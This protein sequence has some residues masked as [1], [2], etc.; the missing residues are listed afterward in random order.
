MLAREE[1][2]EQA[3]F[4]RVL[5]ERLPENFPMQELM[6]QIK[7]ELLATT[8]LPMAI[9]YLLTELRH[10]GVMSG[11]MKRLA[12]YF[13]PYQTYIVAEAENER[14]RFDMRV[15]IDI[16]RH[17]AA[18]RAESPTPA[19][20]FMYQFETIC[21]NRLRYDPGLAAIARD[22]M[23]DKD[24]QQWILTVRRQIGLIDF[25][26]LIYVRS[27]EYQTTRTVPG[28]PEPPPEKPILF[29][30]K[31]G[32]IALANRRK[33]P[34][35]LFA[36]L[37]RHLNYPMAPRLKRIDESREILPQLLR[38]VERLET[39]IKLLEEENRHGIDITKF[40]AVPEKPIP[41]DEPPEE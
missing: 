18:Y 33:D 41:L 36:A 20:L 39:R 25:A 5:A 35:Y 38:R 3:Y 21:R 31:E 27:E 26:D 4:F 24:W 28:E 34:I 30:S 40:Y 1:Y 32:K 9:D 17:E 6:G 19:G 13:T 16:L 29:G 12:H 7:H 10:A 22:P 23:F 2:I 37:Q 14:G 8:R 15:A 11:G